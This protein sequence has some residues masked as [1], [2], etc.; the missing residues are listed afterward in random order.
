MH[1]CTIQT[2]RFINM[3]GSWDDYKIAYQVALDGS[4]SK[5]GK[6][7][8]LNHATVLRRVNQLEE[9]LEI[10]LFIRHQRGYKLTDAGLLL[11]DEMPELM[12]RFATLEN[13]L[14]HIERDISGELR[15]TTVSLYSPELSLL[16]NAF[17]KAYPAIRIK[18]ITTD[19]IIPL[20]SGV[21]HVSIRIG[22][23]MPD[24]TDLIVK[25]I[26][27]IKISYYAHKD[28]VAEYGL[29]KSPNEFN[30][31]AWVL[32]TPNKHRIPFIAYVIKHIEKNNIV[33]QCNNF[34]D[35]SQAVIAGMGIGPMN[36]AQAKDNSALIPVSMTLP[37][38]SNETMWFIYHKDL[39]HSA[40]IKRFYDFL[41]EEIKKDEIK[42]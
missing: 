31:H 6:S 39:K 35:V 28:Y 42:R 19:D 40:R 1:I 36:E 27:Q 11:M 25:K 9:A 29:P 33:F 18:L 10:K 41:I 5:A 22:S 15:I 20:D 21:A 38:N 8:N 32:P 7:L 2:I 37:E 30:Q 14:Q 34:P 23:A 12:N 4:L 17:R 26:N 3:N 13:Q 16:L 24:G